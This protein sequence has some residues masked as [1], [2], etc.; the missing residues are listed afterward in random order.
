MAQVGIGTTSPDKNLTIYNENSSL[1]IQDPRNN[2]DA[3]SS[4]EL[5]NGSNNDFDKNEDTYG[6]KISNSNELF[7]IASGN[8]NIIND[9][10]TI[11]GKT[12][13][14]G[15]GTK[16]HIYI[17]GTDEDEFKLNKALHENN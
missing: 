15:I 2:I 4:I 13:N 12:G 16:P 7:N 5:V 3:V 17:P 6:W 11:D 10:F 8:N 1:S 9:R 14:I